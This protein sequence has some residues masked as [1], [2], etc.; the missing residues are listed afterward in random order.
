MLNEILLTLTVCIDTYL[1]AVNYG[2]RGIKIPIN[3]TF[4]ISFIGAAMLFIA[5]MI[6]QLFVMFI[7]IK[8]CS[9]IGFT[10]LSFI[11]LITILKSI[12]RGII[13]KMSES[14]DICI[15]MSSIGLGI[16]LCL[17]ETFADTDK[18]QDLSVR[19]AAALAI[20]LSL[21]SAA[22]G[23]NAGFLDVNSIRTSIFVF[24]I[25][26]AAVGL[27]CLTGKKIS[28][29]KHDFSWLGGLMLIFFAIIGLF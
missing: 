21:D 20:A 4:T 11:G 28:K 22:A 17:D 27:G 29:C 26:T 14:G 7:P 5:L 8:V 10:V 15:K 6:S 1:V 3:S 25:G 12:I 23:I 13:R 2:A 19:E 16:K 24:I 18:S 9:L